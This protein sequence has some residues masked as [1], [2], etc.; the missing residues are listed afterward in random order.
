MRICFHA[1]TPSSPTCPP[2]RHRSTLPP[3]SSGTPATGVFPEGDRL[4][5]ND[6]VRPIQLRLPPGSFPASWPLLRM[7]LQGQGQNRQR[8]AQPASRAALS[9]RHQTTTQTQGRFGQDGTSVANRVR[10]LG[11]ASYQYQL[12]RHRPSL[13]QTVDRPPSTIQPPIPLFFYHL[14]ST[15]GPA[16]GF[17]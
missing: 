14:P 3:G 8:E 17:G 12:N 7:D 11:Q 15:H 4:E 5:A 1:L 16:G 2:R 6:E 9:G 13:P 10:S